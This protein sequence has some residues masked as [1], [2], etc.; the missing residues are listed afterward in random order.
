MCLAAAD[1]ATWGTRMAGASVTSGVAWVLGTAT[2]V[3]GG[4]G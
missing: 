1:V 3:E 2:M 4:G